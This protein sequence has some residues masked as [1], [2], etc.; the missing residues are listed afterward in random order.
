MARTKIAEMRGSA[1]TTGRGDMALT[2][3]RTR[4]GG[5]DIDRGDMRRKTTGEVK[6]I[7]HGELRAVIVMATSTAHGEILMTRI[8]Q[9]V[10]RDQN[11][12][13]NPTMNTSEKETTANTGGMRNGETTTKHAT[14]RERTNVRVVIEEQIDIKAPIAIGYRMLTV[15]SCYMSALAQ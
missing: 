14:A 5:R 2:T 10:D 4:R 15:G 8:V 9:M 13:I 3:K 11:A 6:N 7:D 1:G 12:T